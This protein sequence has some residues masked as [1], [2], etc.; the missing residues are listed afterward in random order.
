MVFKKDR[1]KV[2]TNGGRGLWFTEMNPLSTPPWVLQEDR[3]VMGPWH[4]HRMNPVSPALPSAASPSLSWSYS[5]LELS[6]Y[7][8]SQ[9]ARIYYLESV[10]DDRSS[11]GVSLGMVVC[12]CLV[13]KSCLILCDTMCCSPPSFPVCGISQARIL[14]WVA[15][16]FPQEIFLT[17]GSNPHLLHWQADSL[18][19]SHQ[20]S[21]P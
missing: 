12:C 9:F 15:I 13:T 19:L 21:Q 18:P 16:S 17:Q 11:V 6:V 2:L 10:N 14:E 7:T 3:R 1:K 4:A 8:Q 20:G 5:S